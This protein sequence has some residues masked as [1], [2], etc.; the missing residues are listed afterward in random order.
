MPDCAI[1]ER[2][3]VLPEP[4]VEQFDLARKTDQ[5]VASARRPADLTEGGGALPG[6]AAGHDVDVVDLA[7]EAVRQHRGAAV[8]GVIAGGEPQ[9]LGAPLQGSEVDQRSF[10]AVPLAETISMPPPRPMV[11]FS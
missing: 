8:Q 2:I 3:A 7:E 9:R 6:R 10:T 11:M 4:A 5:P 1:D